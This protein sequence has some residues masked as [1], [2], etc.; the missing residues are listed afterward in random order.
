MTAWSSSA[1]LA[2]AAVSASWSAK[3]GKHSP[4]T[5]VVRLARPRA[6]PLGTYPSSR[7]ASMTFSRVRARTESGFR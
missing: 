4:S 5:P 7:A 2:A 3:S 6:L 1:S